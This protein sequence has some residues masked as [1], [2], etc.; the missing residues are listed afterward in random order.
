M[1]ARQIPGAALGIVKGDEL[2]YANGFGVKELGG[3]DPVAPDTNFLI[4]SVTKSFTG[5]GVMQLVEQ[6]LIDLDAP[7]TDYLPYFTLAEPES[8]EITVR[9]LLAHTS[10]M[11]D[12][13]DFDAEQLE[14]E[15]P[16]GDGALEQYIK[17]WS[18]A[19]LVF[20]PGTDWKYSTVGIDVLGDIIAKASGQ[21]F[22][23]YMDENVLGPLGMTASTFNLDEVN[24]ENL[25][26]PHRL[27]GEQA[28]PMDYI[29][30]AQVHA[31]GSGLITTVED[32]ARFAIANMNHGTIQDVEYMPATVYEEMW[33]PQT[34]PT[35]WIDWLGTRFNHYGLG[36]WVGEDGGHEAIGNYGASNGANA[37]LEILPEHRHGGDLPGQLH[38]LRPAHLPR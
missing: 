27:D 19:S 15:L 22:E 37:H 30:W 31:P 4:R 36:W 10:G 35:P 14:S 1:A 2:V 16:R 18:D 5:V 28:V 9:Q 11:P 24:P 38:G 17:S 6:G 25:V 7:V 20:P 3:D 23:E 12:V 13:A 21:T 29:V 34:P 33:Q 26:T 8:R 32:M